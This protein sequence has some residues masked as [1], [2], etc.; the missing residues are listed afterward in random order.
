MLFL[1]LRDPNNVPRVVFYLIYFFFSPCSLPVVRCIKWSYFRDCASEHCYCFGILPLYEYQMLL[2]LL[3][4]SLPW[5]DVTC[6]REPT[7]VVPETLLLRSNLRKCIMINSKHIFLA[8]ITPQRRQGN[9][10]DINWSGNPNI[11][12]PCSLGFLFN[13]ANPC[14]S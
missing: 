3:L 2:M 8:Y 7:H 11:S 10:V 13:D 14:L 12:L 9:W 5:R 6:E 1:Y 4:C